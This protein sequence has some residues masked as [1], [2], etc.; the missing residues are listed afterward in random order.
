MIF[1]S[2]IILDVETGG[3]AVVKI[4][5]DGVISNIFSGTLESNSQMIIDLNQFVADDFMLYIESEDVVLISKKVNRH[6]KFEFNL[7]EDIK[8]PSYYRNL[9]EVLNNATEQDLVDRKSTRLNSSHSGESR[10]PSSA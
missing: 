3:T 6:N 1:V 7:D 4:N 5:N 10:M 9:I 8:E 2:R